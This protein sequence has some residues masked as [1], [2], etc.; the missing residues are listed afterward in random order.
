[1]VL[2]LVA[3]AS[4][5]LSFALVALTLLSQRHAPESTPVAHE[6]HEDAAAVMSRVIAA[7][8]R[9]AVLRERGALTAKEFTEQKAK[10]LAPRPPVR[11]R[12]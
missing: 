6:Q 5:T 2:G 12:R 9:L 7:V 1:M 10:L 3:L 8:E 11:S 4:V